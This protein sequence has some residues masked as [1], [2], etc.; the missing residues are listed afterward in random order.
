MFY[1]LSRIIIYIPIFIMAFF[2]KKLRGFLKKRLFQKIDLK[3]PGKDYV[4]IHCASVGEVNLSESLVREFLENTDFKIL[5]T[6]IT[7][8]GRAT[9][10]AKYKND[11][12][13]DLLYFPID[14]FFKIREILAKINLKALVIIETEIWP[15]LIRMSSKK[16]KVVFANGR[17]SDKSFKSYKKI[18]FYLKKLFLNVDFFLMQ[19]EEDK[20]RIIDI[21][22]LAEKVENFG[23]LKFDVKLNDF[24]EEQLYQIR[25]ELGLENRKIFVAGSTRNDEE[26]FILDAYDKLKDYFLILVPRHIER[27]TDI[28]GRLLKKKYRYEK[29]STMEEGVKKDTQVLL[30]DEMGVLRK[31]YALCD[32]AFVG[33]TLVNIGGHSLIEPLYYRKPPIFGKYLQ[34]V[35]EISKEII[36]RKIGYKVE[37]T[38][39]FVAA[40]QM[41]EKKQVNLDD[42]DRFFLENTDVASKT[43]KRIIDII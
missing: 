4:W 18:S 32:V 42:I 27:T 34:N 20:N 3:N 24:T 5:I 38:Q 6:M 37:N 30:V 22:A 26:E 33:G 10:E 19:T 1:N 9:A 36:H 40:V 2:K 7:D 16:S 43:F 17:I 14:D 21:G 15:N 31:L 23:N 25:K 41:V 12:N 8:T 11:K 35:K 13:I 28:E 39:E 29:W